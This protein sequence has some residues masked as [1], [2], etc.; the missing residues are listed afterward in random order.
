[1]LEY[2]V[3]HPDHPI[4]SIS[5][6]ILG[7]IV[8]LYMEYGGWKLIMS[9]VNDPY[10]CECKEDEEFVKLVANSLALITGIPILFCIVWFFG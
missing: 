6:K 2:F 5:A 1:M 7:V 9:G 3:F 8:L 4:L 10:L